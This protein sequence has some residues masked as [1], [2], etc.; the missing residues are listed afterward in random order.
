MPMAR[1]DQLPNLNEAFPLRLQAD[2]DAA[3]TIMP[4]SDIPR[5]P[6]D[7]GPVTVGGQSLRIP[8]R[9][10]NPEPDASAIAFLSEEQQQILA[11]LYTRHHDGHVRQRVLEQ[12]LKS[13]QA[14]VAPFVVQL[15]GEYVVEIVQLIQDHLSVTGPDSLLAF[16]RENPRFM[17]LTAQRATSYWDCYYRPNFRY[18]K[19]YPGIRALEI[20]RQAVSGTVRQATGADVAAIQRVRHAVRENRLVST[21]ISDA[22]VR[23]AIE[24]TGRGWVIE[25]KGEVV[26]FAIGNAVTGNVWALFVH[27][28]HERKGYGRRLHDT[29][30]SWLSSQGVGR[31]WLT[32]EPGTRAQTFYESAGWELV[33]STDHGELR[34]ER[35]ST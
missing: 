18:L 10:Y 32:T 14:W 33:G 2:V 4:M 6:D 9:I 23:E 20:L 24:Q 1:P 35:S 11:C 31:L 28:D 29:M 22:D 25:S 13:N 5:S 8:S 30:V 12:V 17:E 27:F 19:D 16:V 21:T 15:L 7:V 34:Y 26:A 3:L